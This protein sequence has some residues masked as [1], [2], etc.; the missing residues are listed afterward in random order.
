VRR[1]KAI[2]QTVRSEPSLAHV[3][4]IGPS[5]QAVHADASD[6]RALAAA[7]LNRYMDYAAMHRYPAGHYPD[8]LIDQQ[9]GW[10]RSYWG[11]RKT[12][13]T[14]SGYNNAL[15]RTAGALAVPEDV[16]AAYAPSVLLEAV[17]RNCSISWYEV[18]DD[19]DPGAKNVVESNYGLFALRGG[20]APPWRA[21]PAVGELT[22]FLASLKDPGPG[23]ATRGIRLKVSSRARDLRTTVVQKRNGRTAVFL[24][25]ATD[26]WDPKRQARIPVPRVAVTVRTAT[27]NR[28]FHVDHRVRRVV[29]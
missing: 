9:L 15:A 13:I 7:G 19:A 11:G 12:R 21:K 24:R 25:R 3:K 1:Q 23:F 20:T 26:C 29:L 4:V 5:L 28:T 2:W 18:L 10:I 17:D 22:T 14:E 8:Q 6:Y 16:S 27:G